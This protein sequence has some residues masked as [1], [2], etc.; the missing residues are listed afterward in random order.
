MPKITLDKYNNLTRE[1]LIKKVEHMELR[2]KALL[3][4]KKCLES[5]ITDK[6]RKLAAVIAA[7]D[8]SEERINQIYS[9]AEN[10]KKN[11]N[12]QKKTIMPIDPWILEIEVPSALPSI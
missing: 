4:R 6:N 11:Q 8:L 7:T 12:S 9:E 3:H 2:V 10:K 1:D 5:D